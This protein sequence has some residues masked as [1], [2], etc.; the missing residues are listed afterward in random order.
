VLAES[1]GGLLRAPPRLRGPQ[2]AA[3]GFSVPRQRDHLCAHANGAV[4]LPAA[5]GSGNEEASVSAGPP[6]DPRVGEQGCRCSLHGY[7]RLQDE[8]SVFDGGATALATIL[9]K[10]VDG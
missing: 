9:A 6:D 7:I 2:A 3:S 4:M 10:R 5:V 1:G 8:A